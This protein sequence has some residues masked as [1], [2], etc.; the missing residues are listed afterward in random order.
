MKTKTKTCTAETQQRRAD[1]ELINQ[2]VL[3]ALTLCAKEGIQYD[4]MTAFMD[5]SAAHEEMPLR[6]AHL[7][8]A[9]EFNFAHDVLGIRRHMNRETAKLGDCFV[10]RFAGTTKPALKKGPFKHAV[11]VG[12]HTYKRVSLN[13]QYTHVV[14]GDWPGGQYSPEPCKG[15]MLGWAGSLE[16][17]RKNVASRRA[18]NNVR[19][20]DAITGK[21]VR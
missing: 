13:R 18:Y 21:E 20:F 10:P 7:L 5:I 8:A 15:I 4:R 12:G 19:I 2:I 17:A 1:Y 11:T 14:I 6:L 9:D 3:R 16:L